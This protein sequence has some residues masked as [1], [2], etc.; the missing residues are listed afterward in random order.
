MLGL[1]EE[2]PSKARAALGA[3]GLPPGLL[4][5]FPTG[6]RP[7]KI[8]I[9]TALDTIESATV[10]H[11]PSCHDVGNAKTPA[12]SDYDFAGEWLELLQWGLTFDLLGIA[13]GPAIDVPEIAYRFGCDVDVGKNGCEAVA[14]VPGPHLVDGSHSL[15]IVRAM[16]DLASGLASSLKGVIATYWSPARS[17]M[18]TA[19]FRRSVDTWLSG[20]P[21]PALGL[22]GFALAEDG[23]MISEGLRHFIGQELSIAPDITHD[24]VSATQ[25]G[26]RL[27]HELV[28]SGP[29]EEFRRFETAEGRVVGLTPDN[30]AGRIVVSPM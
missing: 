5:L 21:F 17:A 26:A 23:S 29:V 9:L 27:V 20:G 19:L 28:G 15:P 4:F 30:A 11:D 16:L 25:L 12:K 6:M 3:G 18:G 10:S 14:L 13:P 1:A 22:T 2:E 24:P 7:K 8:D